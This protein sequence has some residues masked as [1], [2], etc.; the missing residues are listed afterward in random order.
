MFLP[1]GAR[2]DDVPCPVCGRERD[3]LT[4]KRHVESHRVEIHRELQQMGRAGGGGGKGRQAW[5]LS[6]L[7]RMKW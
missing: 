7:K 2:H 6:Q 4:M 3:R 5:W 1:Y